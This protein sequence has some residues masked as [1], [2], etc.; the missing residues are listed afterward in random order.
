VH[1]YAYPLDWSGGAIFLGQA[2]VSV[3]R[4]DVG[5]MF[6]AQF[7]QSGFNLTAPLLAAGRYRLVAYAHSVVAGAFTA[8]ALCDVSVR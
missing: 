7:G 2:V 8:V 3:S 6:G 5:A 1:V 4:P